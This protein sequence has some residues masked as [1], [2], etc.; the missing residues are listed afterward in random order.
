[1]RAL[2]EPQNTF[3]LQHCAITTATRILAGSPNVPFRIEREDEWS[4]IGGMITHF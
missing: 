1:M 2:F 3:A 4:G